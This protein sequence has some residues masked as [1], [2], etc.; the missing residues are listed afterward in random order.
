MDLTKIFSLDAD[1][2][3]LES[4]NE[5]L[6]EGCKTPAEVGGHEDAAYWETLG[7]FPS[8]KRLNQLQGKLGEIPDEVVV[9]VVK[10]LG[11]LS[12]KGNSINRK[13]LVEH[14]LPS[15]TDPRQLQPKLTPVSLNGPKGPVT[16]S[17]IAEFWQQ[18]KPTTRERGLPSP[19]VCYSI[20]KQWR[21]QTCGQ[22]LSE[23][24]K[25]ALQH[26]HVC[27]LEAA[28]AGLGCVL[29]K[30][31]VPADHWRQKLVT[32]IVEL[33]VHLRARA[34]SHIVRYGVSI[35]E[36]FHV[37]T[38]MSLR[39]QMRHG[40]SRY[41]SHCWE[42]E[43]R[44]AAEAR[45]ARLAAGKRAAAKRVAAKQAAA[46]QAAAKQAEE[47]ALVAT[48]SEDDGKRDRLVNILMRVQLPP[49]EV[50]GAGASASSSS[51]APSTGY[52]PKCPISQETLEYKKEFFANLAKLQ[53]TYSRMHPV[54]R[55]HVESHVEQ[56]W[57]SF[58][59]QALQHG[60]CQP[61]SPLALWQTGSTHYHCPV[62]HEDIG[63]GFDT[64]G[65]DQPLPVRVLLEPE[66]TVDLT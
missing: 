3:T 22:S 48:L 1:T 53:K 12:K 5:Q 58:Q 63:W 44:R 26:V 6:L 36:Q 33:P 4:L 11:T 47:D 66:G 49:A 20:A 60:C 2:T 38:Q 10:E 24:T 8:S 65:E 7:D 19:H 59:N 29:R 21:R 30:Q 15:I 41:E 40:K 54:N 45:A 42:E 16:E 46:K 27:I 62:C 18:Y 56:D 55:E 35:Y 28:V 61:F 25:T 17:N 23:D 51:A 34:I 37:S 13:K 14:L 9:K 43:R 32:R 50:S 39:H 52:R 57:K 64:V 31:G